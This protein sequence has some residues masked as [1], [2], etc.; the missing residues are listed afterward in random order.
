VLK[1]PLGVL[2]KTALAYEALKQG[3]K[4]PVP[5]VEHALSV[6]ADDTDIEAAWNEACGVLCCTCTPVVITDIVRCN[7]LL[8]CE[9][10]E[11]ADHEGGQS[12]LPCHRAG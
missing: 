8:P 10:C 12:G 2:T 9:G 1:E 4:V 7:R 6:L 11:R 3:A 5:A